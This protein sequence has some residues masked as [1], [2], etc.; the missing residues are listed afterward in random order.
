MTRIILKIGICIVLVAFALGCGKN[1]T[2]QEKSA[3][4]GT[5]SSLPILGKPKDFFPT[6]VGLKWTYEITVGDAEPLRYHKTSW[7]QGDKMVV[8]SYR[9][10]LLTNVN[11]EGKKRFNLIIRSKNPA[12]KHVLLKNAK[13]VELE[14]I[15]DELGVFEYAKQVFWAISTGRGFMVLLVVTYDPLSTPFAPTEFLWD[16]LGQGDGYSKRL[17][18]FSGRPGTGMG[19]GKD[20]TDKLIFDGPDANVEGYAGQTLLRFIRSVGKVKKKGEQS[21][22][23]L[24]RAFTEEMW[25]A[26]GKGL[27]RLVQK[28][29]GKVSMTW[30]LSKVSTD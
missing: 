28:V 24:D 21:E 14:V 10:F 12:A 20:L 27:V 22:S 3:S 25:Y 6:Q 17:L 11:W 23:V 26:K 1:A 29:G 2:A 5:T 8:I 30:T 13:G 16:G 18:F 19:Y 7:P 9:G 15:Q 4:P